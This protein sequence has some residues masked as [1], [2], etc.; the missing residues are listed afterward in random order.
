MKLF[1]LILLMQAAFVWGNNELKQVDVIID[2]P[3]ISKSFVREEGTN[4]TLINAYLSTFS[5]KLLPCVEQTNTKKLSIVEHLLAGPISKAYANHGVVF[6]EPAHIKMTHQS[7]LLLGDKSKIA[8]MQLPKGQYC[9][10][11]IAFAHTSKPL[12][13]HKIANLNN[14]SAYFTIHSAGEAQVISSKY[15]Y[16]E[17][18]DL[19]KKIDIT[20]QS[21][22]VVIS[23]DINAAMLR[24][25]YKQSS[26]EFIREF[27]L[28]LFEFIQVTQK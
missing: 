14:Y 18:F 15:A 17:T 8:E 27:W 20:S 9:A 25:N 26:H 4:V 19:A 11:N 16:G 7:D 1:Y 5:F 2:I 21:S 23:M 24:L 3:A 6:T 12:I 22:K 28:N 13:A 10:A